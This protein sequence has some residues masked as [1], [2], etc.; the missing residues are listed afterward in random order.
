MNTIPDNFEEFLYWVKETTE[1]RWA[2]FAE[3]KKDGNWWYHKHDLLEGA[4]WIDPLSDEEIDALEIKWNIK[5]P[6]DHRSFLKILH[7]VDKD[8][9]FEQSDPDPEVNEIKLKRAPL[10]HNWRDDELIKD[11]FEYPFEYIRY[12]V[13]ES[14]QPKWLKSWGAKPSTEKESQVIVEEWI[15]KAKI[16]IPINAHRFLISELTPQCNHVISIYG[17]DTILYSLNLREHLINELRWDL[18]LD[19]RE[20]DDEEGKPTP[21]AVANAIKSIQDETF[22]DENSVTD[23]E[24]YENRLLERRNAYQPIP[25]WEEVIL[26]YSSGWS[27]IGLKFPYENYSKAQPIVVA[28]NVTIQ[29]EFEA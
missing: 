26:Y 11:R 4:K 9:F 17:F 2:N 6:S 16:L 12:D 19:E 20:Y 28:D 7:R 3:S 21:L 24:Q 10:F 23:E 27:S 14:Q 29:K 13:F 15:E 1:R 8:N 18:G 25:Y 5:F 22:E